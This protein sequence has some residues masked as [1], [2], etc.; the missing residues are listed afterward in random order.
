MRLSALRLPFFGGETF[1]AQ[2]L[3]CDRIART[4]FYFT[5]RRRRVDERGEGACASLSLAIVSATATP[6]HPDLSPRA[7]EEPRLLAARRTYDEWQ[8]E[9]VGLAAHVKRETPAEYRAQRAAERAA[10]ARRDC[11]RL[12]RWRSCPLRRCRRVGGCGGEPL[13]CRKPQPAGDRAASQCRAA[14]I[15]Y[16]RRRRRGIGRPRRSCPRPKRP[17][18]SRPPSPRCR[19]KPFEPARSWKREPRWPHPIRA[20]AAVRARSLILHRDSRAEGGPFVAV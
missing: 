9:I 3:G 18:P 12:G 15:Q 20:A 2:C 11:D 13:Q 19:P 1:R 7:G 16:G 5:S 17:P 10:T 14:P 4:K 8:E 6:P